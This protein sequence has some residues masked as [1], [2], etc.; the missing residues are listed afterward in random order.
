MRTKHKPLLIQKKTRARLNRFAVTNE[1]AYHELA[2]LLGISPKTVYNWLSH[3][4]SSANHPRA[5]KCVGLNEQMDELDRTH[6][7]NKKPRPAQREL[8]L[9]T[10]VATTAK[11]AV[12][13]Q[14]PVK[15]TTTERELAW[16]VQGYRSDAILGVGDEARYVLEQY[17]KEVSK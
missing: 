16:L 17:R 6:Q 8:D 4:P 15:A 7:E 5:G 13:E 1:L 11:P 2:V 14:Q 10:A 12:I 9:Q 3:S